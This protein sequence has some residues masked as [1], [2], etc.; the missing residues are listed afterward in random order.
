MAGED[1]EL[2]RRVRERMEAEGIPVGTDDPT[3]LALG[4]APLCEVE[5][6]TGSDHCAIRSQDPATPVWMADEAGCAAIRRLVDAPPIQ[7]G[8]ALI[9]FP[10]RETKPCP[11]TATAV[12]GMVGEPAEVRCG[13]LEGHS[14]RHRMS[15]EWGDLRGHSGST[16][17]T[18]G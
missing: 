9:Q 18:D 8:G 14:G 1:G 13:L 6:C 5:G 10:P 11:A 16:E 15:I 12:L 2:R 3:L 4:A 7:L 17:D